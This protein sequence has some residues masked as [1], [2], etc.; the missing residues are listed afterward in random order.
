M[1]RIV[2]AGFCILVMWFLSSFRSCAEEGADGSAVSKDEALKI[3]VDCDVCDMDHIR[4]EIT[5]VNYVRDPREADVHILVTTASTASRGLEYTIAFIGR[6][7]FEGMEDTL[8]FFSRASDT[9]ET[10]RRE[11]VRVLKLGL[12]RYVART[13]LAEEIEV[14][15]EGKP[16]PIA[17]Q[18]TWD[19]WV[20]SVSVSSGLTGEKSYDE[21]SFLASVSARRITPDLKLRLSMSG[22]YE[23][24]NFEAAEE[25]V[26]SIRRSVSSSALV[27]R[28]LG[29]HWSVGGLAS[30]SSSTYSNVSLSVDIGPAVEYSVFP[31]SQHT[32]RELSLF[33]QIG[34]M[35][36]HYVHETI[37]DKMYECLFNESLSATLELKHTWGT[38]YTNLGFSHY[39]HDFRK[40]QLFLYNVLSVRVMEGLSLNLN[41]W[42]SLVHDQLSLAKGD[43]S[44]EDVYLRRVQLETQYDYWVSFGVS[45]TFGS[46]YTNVVNP[47][48]GG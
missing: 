8:R 3:Y 40:N 19:N 24:D 15:H 29:E 31:Y 10:K 33:Y 21:T 46:I 42:T 37:Y 14:S 18:D 28:S 25:W 35:D 34:I 45:Y 5:F 48:F 38:T 39:F 7:D 23:E 13:A 30:T 20:F 16:E 26:S 2:F 43:A 6:E 44:L 12:V 17:E 9:R 27:A 4:T 11:M 47:R 1:K 36:V 22:N 32:H 41:G